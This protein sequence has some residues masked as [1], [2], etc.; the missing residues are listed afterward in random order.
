MFKK[1]A[2]LTNL[3]F[4]VQGHAEMFSDGTRFKSKESDYIFLCCDTGPNSKQLAFWAISLSGGHFYWLHKDNKKWSG[5]YRASVLTNKIIFH[6]PGY[7]QWLDR[8]TLQMSSL[9][10]L[11]P[12]LFCKIS[13]A[14]KVENW[15]SVAL[16]KRKI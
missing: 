3:I 13:C 6:P 11:L 14:A 2:F 5:P 9:D 16:L 7:L 1:I 12:N 15:L 10:S 8:T 4:C